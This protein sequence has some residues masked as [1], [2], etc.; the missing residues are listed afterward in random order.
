M[1]LSENAISNKEGQ[2]F[3][4]ALLHNTSFEYL[5]LA[6]NSLKDETAQELIHTLKSNT[7][8][9]RVKLENNVINLWYIADINDRLKSN[10]L[11]ML[12]KVKPTYQKEINRM[13]AENSEYA[14][15]TRALQ[16]AKV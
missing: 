1:D 10:E 9:R 3:M 5:N 7:T 6:A 12:E 11:K 16:G 8:L 4:A 14:G 2:R 15:I 13:R